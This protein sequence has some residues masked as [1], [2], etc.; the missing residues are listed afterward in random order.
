MNNPGRANVSDSMFACYRVLLI[1][2]L[3]LPLLH[4]APAWQGELTS[5]APGAF[6]KLVPSVLELQVS[7]NGTIDAGRIRM[8][9]APPD[10]KKAGIYVVRSSASSLGAAAVLFPYK[11]NFWSEISSSSLQPRFFHAVE[12]DN[13]ETVTTTVRHFPDRVESQAIAKQTKSGSSKQTD[14]TFKF[15]PVFDIFSAMLHVRSQKLD[16]GDRITLALH[17]F[18]TPYLLRV[19]VEGRE[20]HNGRN[21]IRL[22]LGMRKI[23][24]KT[25]ELL[26]YKKL[27]QDATLWLSDDADRIPIEFRASAFIGD[28]RATLVSHRKP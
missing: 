10:I 12:I 21:T 5:P 9:F 19:K 16:A 27:K 17:P 25:L 3:S 13:R 23:D 14:R 24:R 1:F 4:A 18:E 15:S 6:S 7:W 28:V 11:T 26:P 20:I 2:L 8:E 22:T